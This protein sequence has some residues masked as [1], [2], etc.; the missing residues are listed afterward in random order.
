VS[1][2]RYRRLLSGDKESSRSEWAVGKKRKSLLA[3]ITPRRGKLSIRAKGGP[4]V[5]LFKK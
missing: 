5:E 1:R 3:V 4:D 2:W